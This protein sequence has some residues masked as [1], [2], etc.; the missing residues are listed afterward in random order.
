MAKKSTSDKKPKDS[1]PKYEDLVDRLE[2]IVEQIESGELDLEGSIRGYEEGVS[3]LKGAKEILDQA[4]QRIEALGPGNGAP[5]NGSDGS[6][7]SS[8]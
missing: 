4:E 5:D 8:S 7:G 6:S 2:E 1:Q 3:L